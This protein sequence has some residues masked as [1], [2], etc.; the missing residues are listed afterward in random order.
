MTSARKDLCLGIG[1]LEIHIIARMQVASDWRLHLPNLCS[2]R[3]LVKN[4]NKKSF[5][6]GVDSHPILPRYLSLLYHSPLAR[7]PRMHDP[8]RLTD[9]A[10]DKSKRLRSLT[11][12]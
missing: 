1:D 4:K 9:K 5:Q 8:A 11:L 3:L 12:P 2:G 6:T 10:T 7:D